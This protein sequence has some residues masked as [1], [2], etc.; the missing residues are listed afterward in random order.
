[1]SLPGIKKKV[2]SCWPLC[3]VGLP[4]FHEEAHE[5]VGDW[6][7][8]V[9]TST[10]SHSSIAESF[11]YSFFPIKN[12]KFSAFFFSNVLMIFCVLY[13]PTQY[14]SCYIILHF[15]GIP[16]IHLLNWCLCFCLG[17]ILWLGLFGLNFSTLPPVSSV[18]IIGN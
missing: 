17:I 14:L 3:W 12:K 4:R 6:L 13:H 8:C 1:M 18:N 16:F 9:F 10:P 5:K 11:G 7:F 15:P 2:V